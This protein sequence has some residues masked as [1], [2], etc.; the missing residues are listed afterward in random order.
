M[1]NAANMKGMGQYGTL[2]L[3]VVLSILFGLW[4]GTKLDDWLHTGPYLAIVWFAFGCAAA[5]RA[6]HRAWKGMQAEAKR[7]EA[8]HGNPAQLFPDEK[9]RA[10]EREA[11]KEREEREA[12]AKEAAR[13]D[14]SALEKSED[15]ANAPAADADAVGSPTSAEKRDD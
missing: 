15:G 1:K 12:R 3:E 2:G 9:S 11:K 7:E 14:D 5:G 10:W 8:E 6:V 13:A 4:I